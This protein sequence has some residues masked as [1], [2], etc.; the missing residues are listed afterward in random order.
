[1]ISRRSGSKRAPDTAAAS[2][3]LVGED[4]AFPHCRMTNPSTCRDIWHGMDAG[5]YPCVLE[6]SMKATASSFIL[7]CL[8]LVAAAPAGA[9]QSQ[10]PDPLPSRNDCQSRN[11]ITRFVTRVT[12]EGGPDFVPAAQRIAVF[13][14]DGTL[15]CEQ[16]LYVQF[17]FAMDRV[18]ALAPQHPEWK[19]TEPFKSVLAGDMKAVAAQS[20]KGAAQLLAATLHFQTKVA[21]RGKVTLCSPGPVEEVVLSSAR[22]LRRPAGG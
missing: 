2:N 20:E 9:R 5:H 18:K 22:R 12:T 7:A 1:M 17:V 8:A 19:D 16:P 21:G 11:E 14:N 3:V 4:M 13:D 6:M 10:A 15:W